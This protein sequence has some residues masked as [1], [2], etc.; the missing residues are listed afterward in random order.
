MMASARRGLSVPS[1]TMGAEEAQLEA[2]GRVEGSND[3]GKF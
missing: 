3:W 2:A 1:T